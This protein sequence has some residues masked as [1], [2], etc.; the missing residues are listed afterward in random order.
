MFKRDAPFC[1]SVADK[2]AFRLMKE[3]EEIENAQLGPSGAMEA[4][5]LFRKAFKMSPELAAVY[6]S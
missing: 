4:A 3:A 2:A 5:E 6:G 1:D